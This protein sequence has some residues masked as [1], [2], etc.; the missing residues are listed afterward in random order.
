MKL[1]EK[2]IIVAG[3]AGEVGEGIVKVLL[4]EGAK[5]IIPLRNERKGEVLRELLGNPYNLFFIESRVSN[6]EEAENLKKEALDQFGKI[7]MVVASLGG[8]YQNGRLDE[9]PQEDWLVVMNNSLNAHFTLAKVMMNYFHS[10][11]QGMY[12]M[13]NG[14]ASEMVV[15]QAGI[16]S[17]TAAAQK[18]IAQVLHYEAKDTNIK[19]YSVAAFT[20]VIT[21]S[22]PKGNPNWVSAEDIG[23]YIAQ[24]YA[25]D[26]EDKI[27][28]K[29][30]S[31]LF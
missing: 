24:L 13:I 8:W 5:V 17:V 9:V 26:K 1:Q 2:I 29:Q 21:R 22:R 14:G 4:N 10:T 27:I 23:T 30:P 20:P 7:D 25:T 16:M 19:V 18:M 28:H 11:N 15:P 31:K 3:G 6:L 12:V